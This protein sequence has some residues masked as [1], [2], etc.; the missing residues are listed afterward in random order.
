MKIEVGYVEQCPLSV[1]TE[2]DFIEIKKL[3]ENHDKN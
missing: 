1:D 2:E 3:M